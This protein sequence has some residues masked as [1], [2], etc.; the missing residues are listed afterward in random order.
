MRLHE[1]INEDYEPVDQKET[2]QQGIKKL[3]RALLNPNINP[4]VKAKIEALLDKYANQ[5]ASLEFSETLDPAPFEK[6]QA[7]YKAQHDADIEEFGLGGAER[8]KNSPFP[9][10]T[11]G[12]L[13]MLKKQEERAERMRGYGGGTDS[14]TSLI[15]PNGSSANNNY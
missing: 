10:T 11:R 9:D 3:Q 12:N 13:R 6:L 5:D 4:Q 2:I 15:L 14:D 8:I 1:F 7:E